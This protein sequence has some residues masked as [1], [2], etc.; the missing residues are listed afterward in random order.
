MP[1]AALQIQFSQGTA[2]RGRWPPPCTPPRRKGAIVLELKIFSG[3]DGL[4]GIDRPAGATFQPGAA[5][6]RMSA[7]RPIQDIGIPA[8]VQDSGAGNG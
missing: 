2:P 1:R 4:G 6:E 3:I 8:A 7:C 5:A